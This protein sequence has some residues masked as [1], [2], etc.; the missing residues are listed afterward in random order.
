MSD[1]K[2]TALRKTIKAALD[3][4]PG[5]TYYISATNDAV[6]PYKTFTMRTV[7]ITGS[8]RDDIELTVDIW[9]KSR[10][11]S[12]A[13]GI[14]DSIENLFNGAN[15]PQETIL[16]TIWGQSRYPVP[17]ED[18]SFQHIQMT[19]AIQNYERT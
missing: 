13:E 11:P 1:T 19:F 4:V 3:T 18:K 7:Q 8:A 14:A 16:P 6:F 17:D 12:A 10:S 15:I 9:D 5:K 2:T